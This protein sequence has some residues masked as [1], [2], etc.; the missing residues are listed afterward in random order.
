MQYNINEETV[1]KITDLDS[2]NKLYFS[3]TNIPENGIFIKNTGTK[4]YDWQRVDNLLVE[5]LGNKYFEFGV[6]DDLYSC[7]IEFPEDAEDLIKDGI[8]ITYVTTDGYEGNIQAGTLTK[9]TNDLYLTD[10]SSEA[11]EVVLNVDNVSMS[12]ALVGIGGLDPETIDEAYKNYR[13][14][15]GTF[16][17]LVTLRDYMNSI[18]QSGLVSNCFVCDS[19]TDV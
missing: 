11:S 16:D 14:L 13:Y 15:V 17:T 3:T 1:I 5:K 10:T 4:L 19:T 18:M 6:T 8:E 7:Y 12:N 9:F 2:E